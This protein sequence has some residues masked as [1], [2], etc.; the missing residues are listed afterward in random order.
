M[1]PGLACEF[2][3]FSPMLEFIPVCVCLHSEL[4]FLL[5]QIVYLCNFA[6]FLGRALDLT[7]VT[8]SDA[9]SKQT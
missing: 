8:V 7:L 2:L 4:R 1:S 3:I 6:I 5:S 9:V